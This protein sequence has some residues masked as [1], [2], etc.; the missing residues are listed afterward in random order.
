VEAAWRRARAAFEWFRPDGRLNDRV[1]AEAEIAAALTELTGSEWKTVGN[2]L[3]DRCSLAFLDRMHQR[4]RTA[5]PRAEWSE[6]L[7]WRWWRSRH[8]DAATANPRTALVQAAALQQPHSDAEQASYDRIAVVLESTV[9][10]SSAVECMN[11]VL[12]MHQSRHRRMTQP[13]LDLKRLY[14]E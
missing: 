10:A 14:L 13:M 2:F 4:L 8:P 12:R 7:A 5:E 6:M 1:G 11:S 3:K 9:R